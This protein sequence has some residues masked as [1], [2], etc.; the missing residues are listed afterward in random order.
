MI[1]IGGN[2]VD[3][4]Q[5]LAGFERVVLEEIA[6]EMNR[7]NELTVAHIK[8][9]RATG[10]GPFPVDEHRLG[11]RTGRYRRSIRRSEARII[12]TTAVVS[13]IG[14]NVAYAGTH[15]FGFTGVVDVKGHT[16]Q[17]A[18]RNVRGVLDGKRRLVAKGIGYV[19][20]HQRRMASAARAPITTGIMDR[21]ENY[22][23]A[24]SNRIVGVYARLVKEGKVK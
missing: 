9:A 24:V 19:K 20:P 11:V 18:S 16:R 5:R 1:R 12:G 10:Q 2:A 17:V 15:E 3:A 6:G 8:E 13:T 23:A 14:S 4:L 21:A 22:G 7:Q